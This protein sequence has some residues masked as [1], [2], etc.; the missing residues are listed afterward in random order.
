MT[1]ID[2][3]CCHRRGRWDPPGRPDD[4]V[5]PERRGRLPPRHLHRAGRFEVRL[6]A[7]AGPASQDRRAGRP[8]VAQPPGACTSTSGPNCSSS[9]PSMPRSRPSPRSAISRSTTS[10]ELAA[11]YTPDQ[12]PPSAE[13]WVEA[14]VDAVHRGARAR[15]APAARARPGAGRQLHGHPLHGIRRSSA[16]SRPWVAVDGGMSDNLRPMMY[17]CP[18]ASQIIAD[19]PLAAGDTVCHVAGKHC[20][21]GDVIRPRRQPA[22]TRRPRRGW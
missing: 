1:M 17:G 22:P 11:A 19:R 13:R 4:R 16:T 9:S 2:C 5:T 21:S 10:A 7:G 20:E 3:S 18:P 12:L 14:I 15:Q 6:L 8:P